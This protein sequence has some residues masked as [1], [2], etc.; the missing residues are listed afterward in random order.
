VFLAGLTYYPLLLQYSTNKI[1]PA[2]NDVNRK[3]QILYYIL[4]ILEIFEKCNQKWTQKEQAYIAAPV[5]PD[6]NIIDS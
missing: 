3:F 2:L 4:K 6:A 1:P 5:L